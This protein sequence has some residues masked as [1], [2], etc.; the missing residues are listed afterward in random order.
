MKAKLYANESSWDNLHTRLCSHV[1]IP[2]T[3]ASSYAKKFQVREGHSSEAGKWVMKIMTSGPY[4]ADDIV[5]GLV[6]YDEDWQEPP[7]DL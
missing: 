4:K 7:E 1:G 6:N 2:S 5:S 3:A